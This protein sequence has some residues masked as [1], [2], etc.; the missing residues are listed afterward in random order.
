[1]ESNCWI[2]SQLLHL[3]P[4][5]TSARSSISKSQCSHLGRSSIFSS[6]CFMA[7]WFTFKIVINFEQYFACGMR[8]ELFF[9]WMSNH[10]SIIFSI[11][12][13][14]PSLN[15]LGIFIESQL[16]IYVYIYL[17]ILFSF[18]DQYVFPLS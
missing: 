6:R 9:I 4:A 2:E 1:M 16:S 15:Y 3:V 12:L 8:H 11:R 5:Y 10:S 7:S 18:M 14:F 17:E 13:L